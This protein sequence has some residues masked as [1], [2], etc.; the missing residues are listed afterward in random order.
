[1]AT[2][3]VKTFTNKKCQSLLANGLLSL[4]HHIGLQIQ[5]G[6]GY[7]NV[8]TRRRT[9]AVFVG[10]PMWEVLKP[11]LEAACSSSLVT[12]KMARYFFGSLRRLKKFIQEDFFEVAFPARQRIGKLFVEDA[13]P[14]E[15]CFNKTT[16]CL[17]VC[18]SF[19]VHDEDGNIALRPGQPVPN[20]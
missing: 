12:G 14:V 2:H 11:C 3:L 8:D 7:E 5:R 16:T 15:F 20:A 6:I 1:M 17:R 10:E 13:H 19:A 9:V 4:Q 18:F